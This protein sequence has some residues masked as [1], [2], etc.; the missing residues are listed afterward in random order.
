[1]SWFE[2]EGSIPIDVDDWW[3]FAE[4]FGGSCGNQVGVWRGGKNNFLSAGGVFFSQQL[5]TFCGISCPLHKNFFL[6][7][8]KA[9]NLLLPQAFLFSTPSLC[10]V[11]IGLT[12]T[13]IGCTR[14]RSPKWFKSKIR[15][16]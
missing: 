13:D 2:A 11:K 5:R 3:W 6:S 1:M 8:F 14:R 15:Q 10:P 16:C 4:E 9:L 12:C 7:I